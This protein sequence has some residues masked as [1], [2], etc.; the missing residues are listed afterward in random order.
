MNDV[1]RT[2]EHNMY[3]VRYLFTDSTIV[4]FADYFCFISSGIRD[5]Q[6]DFIFF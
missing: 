3:R 1:A 5:L 4:I 2:H 6:E